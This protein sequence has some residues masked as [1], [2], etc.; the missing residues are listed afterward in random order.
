MS[1]LESLGLTPEHNLAVDDMDK[2]FRGNQFDY[3][4]ASTKDMVDRASN[5][6]TSVMSAA[7]N[8]IGRPLYD[9]VDAS[10]EYSKPG[11]GYQGEFSLTPRGA[12]DFGKNMWSLGGEF[13]DQ[14]PGTMMAGALKGG[15]ESLGTQLGESIYDKFNPS[16]EEDD[17]YDFSGIEG[18]TAFNPFAIGKGVMA[19]GGKLIPKELI[20]M[21][22][23]NN[24]LE[25]A[26][27]IKKNKKIIPS[28]LTGGKAQATPGGYTA[29]QH[30]G[31]VSQG[32]GYQAP[33]IR[34]AP[35]GVTTS[36]GMHGGKHYAIGG[37]ASYFD[38]GLLSLWPR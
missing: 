11:K 29:P 8:V 4:A 12:L 37:R 27:K 13:L 36:S 35:K 32:G 1:I 19:F 10:K 16:Y 28:I 18:Q 21:W 15:I 20:Q 26:G 38:G 3:A 25:A 22:K 9:F 34:S 23:M 5:P 33:N 6:L 7:G 17:E 30:H 24:A 14:K 31:D 2:N